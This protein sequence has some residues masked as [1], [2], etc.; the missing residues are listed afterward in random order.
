MPDLREELLE[1]LLRDLSDIYHK[2]PTVAQWLHVPLRQHVPVQGNDDTFVGA[3]QAPEEYQQGESCLR[4]L[5]NWQAIGGQG[6]WHRC[7]L[8]PL[9]RIPLPPAAPWPDSREIEAVVGPGKLHLWLMGRGKPG[10]LGKGSGILKW[11]G[12]EPG[13]NNPWLWQRPRNRCSR[14]GLV[15]QGGRQR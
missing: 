8:L 2:R 10:A 14:A 1:R 15:R 3:T 4:D 13:Q 12:I 6:K 11:G 9:G 5:P 7:N